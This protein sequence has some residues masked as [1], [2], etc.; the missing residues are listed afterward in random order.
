MTWVIGRAGPFGHAIGLSDIRIRFKDGTERDCLQKIYK[1]GPQLV[2][3]FAG[4]VAIGLEIVAE[5]GVALQPPEDGRWDPHYIAE[6]L[7]I[8]T[9]QL[10]SSSPAN[11]RELGCQ[12]MLFSAHPT[13]NDG[14]APWARCYVHRF[15]APSFEPIEAAQADIVSIGSGANVELYIEAL[16]AFSQDMEMFKLE[17][18][19]PGGSGVGLMSSLTS[20]LMRVPT[21]GI[22]RHLHICLV[23]RESVRLGTNDA[24]TSHGDATDEPMPKVAKSMDELKR[25]LVDTPASMLE[26]ATC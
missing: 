20:L 5:L 12:L 2:L 7:P 14:A 6:G 24:F 3:G 21:A 25:I 1:V 22:S 9:R 16:E 11:E 18:G 4:S 26:L 17:Q 13:E 19:F 8:G 23:G 15:Y 10:F